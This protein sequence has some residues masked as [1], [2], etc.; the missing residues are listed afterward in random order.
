MSTAKT[1]SLLARDAVYEVNPYRAPPPPDPDQ[2]AIRLSANESAYGPSPR[3]LAAFKA[4][5]ELALRYP[6]AGQTAL[7]NAIGQRY[8]LPA[9]Y[10]VCGNGSD[11]LI[12]LF[13]RAFVE[14]NAEVLLS[15]NSFVMSVIHSKVQGARLI[16][17]PEQGF[18][19]DVDALIKRIGPATRL[20][21][22]ANPNN[23]TGTYVEESALRRLAEALPASCVFL[24]DEAYAEY[25]TAPDFTSA[26]GW[27]REY[28]NVVVTRTFSKIHALPGLRIGWAYGAPEII[29]VI[30]RIRTPFNT[31]CAALAAATAA[32]G[33]VSYEQFICE[34]NARERDRVHAALSQLGLNVIPSQTNFY[35]IDFSTASARAY[36]AFCALQA[37]NIQIRPAS[38]DDTT[39]RITLGTP[40]QNDR[41]LETLGAYLAALT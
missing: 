9:E 24:V 37:E 11:E 40:E 28:P 7:R 18:R 15:E 4:A 41:V 38:P 36:D 14:P 10:I 1:H 22:I 16:F 25:A 20:C 27:A 3:A 21:T 32:I 19:V 23:P 29:E 17:A 13:V 5:A 35:L 6:D 34:Q 33:D 39:L 12:Q 2:V 8:G 30:N 31:N 26:L